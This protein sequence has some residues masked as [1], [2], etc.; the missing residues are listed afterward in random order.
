MK[1]IK[2]FEHIIHNQ[3]L[4]DIIK[5]GI[6][7]IFHAI[8]HE[9]A[10]PAL[11]ENKLGGYSIQRTWEGGK[12]LK[13]DMPGYEESN[14]LRGIS[15][16]RDINYANS[17]NDVI[18][19][20]DL[21]KI[22]TKYKVVPYNWG[23]SI[24]KGYRQDSRA[25]REREEFIITGFSDSI[26]EEDR[27]TNF[28]KFK[29]MISKPEGYIEPLDKYLIGFYI[30]N[31]LGE[32]MDKNLK[33]YLTNHKKYLGVYN[34]T[35]DTKNEN[36]LSDF[37]GSKAKKIDR[38]LSKNI[39][40]GNWQW[41]I[42]NNEEN[43]GKYVVV[44]NYTSLSNIKNLELYTFIRNNIGQITLASKSSYGI[45]YMVKYENIP[46]ELKSHFSQSPQ[47]VPRYLAEPKYLICMYE[48]FDCIGTYEEC[49][50]CVEANK[51]NL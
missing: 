16:T 12:R 46:H 47:D 38:K 21:N 36:F 45:S 41:G 51:Y 43:I 18:F 5:Q 29:N 20:F 33:S 35:P 9:N 23:Y 11:L 6:S 28:K 3:K 30:S 24:G 32:Y 1:Y 25:K 37:F 14:Y 44:K 39:G 27:E 49:K 15:A 8:K 34:E 22:K 19:V 2:N 13:D 17:W 4:R 10:V 26:K 42:D 31:R 50:L 40:L 48:N 7:P